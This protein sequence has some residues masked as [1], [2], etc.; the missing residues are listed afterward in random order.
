MKRS[1][2]V[3]KSHNTQSLLELESRPR[4]RPPPPKGKSGE[5]SKAICRPQLRSRK[6]KVQFSKL[7]SPRHSAKSYDLQRICWPHSLGRGGRADIWVN[8]N[9]KSLKREYGYYM[10]WKPA[11]MGEGREPIQ[12]ASSRNQYPKWFLKIEP[13][14]WEMGGRTA[15]WRNRN[16]RPELTGVAVCSEN[17][18]P[19]NMD[20]EVERRKR[21]G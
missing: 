9:L 20:L 11:G 19:L 18:K 16:K 12:K 15:R 10:F 21:W 14:K 17:Y 5:I 7:H 8:V 1:G 2:T 6:T 4:A 13:Y 3:H